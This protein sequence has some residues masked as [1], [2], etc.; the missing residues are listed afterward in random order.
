MAVVTCITIGE[1]YDDTSKHDDNGVLERLKQ[2]VKN[3][4]PEG[5][6]E[7][8]VARLSKKDTVGANPD[9][10]LLNKIC[11]PHD[12]NCNGL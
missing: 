10:Q 4:F 12:W 5:W 6:R 9:P 1:L 11:S 7:W 2:L 8:K 3:N